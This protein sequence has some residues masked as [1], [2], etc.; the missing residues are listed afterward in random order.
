MR[1]KSGS[2]H[3]HKLNVNDKSLDSLLEIWNFTHVLPLSRSLLTLCTIPRLERRVEP[4]RKRR[5]TKP[6]RI[7][8][9]CLSCRARKIRCNGAQPTCNNC[10]DSESPC[11][12]AS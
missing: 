2:F 7:S 5:K 3:S 10:T 9:A 4:P 11:V 12:Y 6:N 8:R 1:P